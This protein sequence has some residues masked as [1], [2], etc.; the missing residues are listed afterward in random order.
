VADSQRRLGK[1]ESRARWHELRVLWN[2][3][4]PIGVVGPSVAD[5]EYE[6]Y[7]GPLLRLLENGANQEELMM[8]LRVLVS[9]HMGMTWSPQL[10][11][12]TEAFI[13]RARDW[14]LTHWSGTYV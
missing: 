9:D 7:I 1:A 11:A 10:A 8:Y 13:V 3:Y 12:R 14:Y 2:E 4:D 6:S 5:D